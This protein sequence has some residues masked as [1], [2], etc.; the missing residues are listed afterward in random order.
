MFRES[1]SMGGQ[2]EF[3]HEGGR[4]TGSSPQRLAT[5]PVRALSGD[6]CRGLRGR[7]RGFRGHSRRT[8]PGPQS[9]L[10]ASTR[11]QDLTKRLRLAAA[12]RRD[13]RQKWAQHMN[14]RQVAVPHV[15]KRV[16]GARRSGW[17]AK[18]WS[19]TG[20][21]VCVGGSGRRVPPAMPTART[22]ALKAFLACAWASS[23][24]WML[25]AE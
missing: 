19:A 17:Q 11:G 21:V 16:L 24:V 5:C 25:L 4:A 18:Y 12:T 9:C 20:G 3:G 6:R 2:T 15:P 22:A 23:S 7:S 8:P 14:R 10:S 13:S 1:A